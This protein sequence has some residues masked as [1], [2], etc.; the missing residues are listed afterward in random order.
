MNPGFL[1]EF[2]PLNDGGFEVRV[3]SLHPGQK[4]LT[5][6]HNVPG[7]RLVEFKKMLRHVFPKQPKREVTWKRYF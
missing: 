5:V 3:T 2:Y 4:A 6:A 1:I 7:T